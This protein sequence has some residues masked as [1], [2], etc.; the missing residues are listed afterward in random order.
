MTNNALREFMKESQERE[1]KF[2]ERQLNFDYKNFSLTFSDE[3]Y[4]IP[5]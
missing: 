3:T 5:I 4:H 2:E 1:S